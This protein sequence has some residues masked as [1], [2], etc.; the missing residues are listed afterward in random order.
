[1]LEVQKS[2]LVS[3]ATRDRTND[4][5]RQS[6]QR[7]CFVHLTL[8]NQPVCAVAFQFPIRHRRKLGCILL[9]GGVMSAAETNEEIERQKFV[10]D[11]IKSLQWREPVDDDIVMFVAGNLRAFWNRVQGS[12]S[13]LRKRYNEARGLMKRATDAW[14]RDEYEEGPT[15]EEAMVE[16]LHWVSQ[17]ELEDEIMST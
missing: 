12:N 5:G 8:K 16:A 2:V 17:E 13:E 4:T 1:M 15:A 3:G 14:Y 11:Y 9:L 10:E 7:D 6:Q